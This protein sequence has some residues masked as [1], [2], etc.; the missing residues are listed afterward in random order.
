MT[1]RA[2]TPVRGVTGHARSSP[3]QPAIAFGEVVRTYGELDERA[4]RLA[5]VL[6]GHGAGPGRPVAGV[7]PNGVEL[8]EVVTA[9]AMLGAP[10]L[11]V[12]WHL[13]AGEL[14]YILADAEVAV[15]VGRVGL[16]AE[17]L[18]SLAEHPATVLRVGAGYDEAIAGATPL[19]EAD[20]RSGPEL[21]FY[22]SGTTARP[23]GVVHAGISD[24]A[25]RARGM[26]GQ[27][28]LWGWTP[29]DVYV[30]TGPAY[31]AA[32]LGWALTALY[33]GA[34]TV[35]TESF[36]ARGWLEEVSRRGGTRTFMVP[37]HFIRILELPADVRSS[38]DTRTLSLVVHAGAP[39]PVQVKYR[40]IEAFP[41]T[42]IHELYGASEGGATRISPQEWLERPG[43][44]GTPW[45]GVEV[46]ILDEE[47]APVPTGEAGL[48]YIRP[49]GPQRFHYRNDDDSTKK[50]WHED[51]F[52]V[53]D[54]G[55]L[56]A[57][58]Y[59]TITDRVSDLVLWG[60]VNIAPREIEEVLFTHPA[61]VDCAVFGIP[62]ERDGERL[63]AMVQLREDVATD[64]LA[65]HVAAT[66][67]KYKVP[68]EWEI[69]DELPRD[70]NGKVRKRQLRETHVHET[71]LVS[72]R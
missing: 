22:T 59:L 51:A 4:R 12:N 66:L 28:A 24:D 21:L 25:G 7:L 3:E 33:V 6:A 14:A 40:M 56:D 61:V 52:T 5:S 65:G 11:P 38:I 71:E 29:D 63:K 18:A 53:G 57:D 17:L 35:V 16:D 70:A 13:R 42:E 46:R 48:I 50:A 39:C 67:A 36:D 58:G 62:D 10:Y 41:D 54:V 20:S 47:G 9:A 34:L 26:E 64:E 1:E 72:E 45:P 49:A 55:F 15:A 37:A 30:M 32:H 68:H 60:G 2:P 27:V 19:P 31:H 44:V 8:F 43:S 23:K 69:V